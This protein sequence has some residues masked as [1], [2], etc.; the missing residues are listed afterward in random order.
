[1]DGL[2]AIKK[3]I[4]FPPNII[5]KISEISNNFSK[6]VRDATEERIER[7]EQ[8]KLEMELAEGYRV[9]AKLNLK[10]CEDFKF[11]DGENI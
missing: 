1:M 5:T 7:I 6:F 3:N 11:V 8:E 2:K 4:Y 9:K 10:I